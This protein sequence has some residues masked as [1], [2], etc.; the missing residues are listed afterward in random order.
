[1]LK[2]LTIGSY[3]VAV[4]LMQEVFAGEKRGRVRLAPQ[5]NVSV[6]NNAIYYDFQGAFGKD[7]SKYM[8]GVQEVS[9]RTR[10]WLVLVNFHGPMALNL[11]NNFDP[12][13]RTLQWANPYEFALDQFHSIEDVHNLSAL[14]LDWSSEKSSEI[15]DKLSQVVRLGLIDGMNEDD[16][17]VLRAQ[18]DT[19]TGRMKDRM[20]A[21]DAQHK[22]DDIKKTVPAIYDNYI[23]DYALSQGLL[24]N[25]APNYAQLYR[26]RMEKAKEAGGNTDSL[27]K[28]LKE[29]IEEAKEA[30]YENPGSSGISRPMSDVM[31]L[32]SR[33]YVTF[34][35]VP[36]Y[37]Q[38]HFLIG[39]AA[40]QGKK[41][42][43]G[44]DI[45]R[46][47]AGIQ[48]RHKQIPEGI[49][50]VRVSLDGLDKIDMKSLYD[51]A[52]H[53]LNA[54]I[55]THQGDAYIPKRLPE[56]LDNLLYKNDNRYKTS[57]DNYFDVDKYIDI[58]IEK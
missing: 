37:S 17:N 49:I 9:G 2:Y 16:L 31:K 48:I 11:T 47:G 13:K 38:L 18:A 29:I 51:K 1:M 12:S 10:G 27:E 25:L 3:L 5:Q 24:P 52:L 20:A 28:H 32:Q 30:V 4:F 56:S 35:F 55:E 50:T 22:L 43:E 14:L 40:P 23:L 36:P 34:I 39:H 15:D 57:N 8:E 7:R 53:E 45:L 46:A 41:V 26:E 42:V 33:N 21:K 44:R 58:N 19:S 6:L 54:Y